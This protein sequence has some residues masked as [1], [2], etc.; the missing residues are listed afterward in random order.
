MGAT[1]ANAFSLTPVPP[2]LSSVCWFAVADL[3]TPIPGT[4]ACAIAIVYV[5]VLVQRTVAVVNLVRW[6]HLL[7]SCPSSPFWRSRFFY[8]TA[9]LQL[10]AWLRTTPL[11]FS[12]GLFVLTEGTARFCSI[13][14]WCCSTSVRVLFNS[15]WRLANSCGIL[16]AAAAGP[17]TWVCVRCRARGQRTLTAGAGDGRFVAWATLFSSRC[18]SASRTLPLPSSVLP[19]ILPAR[20]CNLPVPAALRCCSTWWCAAAGAAA[21][22]A[23]AAAGA[24]TVSNGWQHRHR[25]WRQT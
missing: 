21:L 25:R 18:R 8:E 23:V 6:C 3:P 17:T 13:A 14:A 2:Q 24:R 7:V 19:G 15:A 1:V 22:P 10:S 12:A 9:C 20:Q 4:L 11:A 16:A 5:A